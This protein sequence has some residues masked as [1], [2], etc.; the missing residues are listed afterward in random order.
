VRVDAARVGDVALDGLD[1]ATLH[2]LS[3]RAVHPALR[4]G[5]ARSI[6]PI[7]PNPNR[8]C[9]ARGERVSER[10]QRAFELSALVFIEQL[11]IL[12]ER[13]ARRGDE[14]LGLDDAL[15]ELPGAEVFFCVFVRV[16]EHALDVLVGQ[17]VAR[18]DVDGVL[19]SGRLVLRGH[20]EHPALVDAKRDEQAS[21]PC[22][23]RFDPAERESAR[24]N[25]SRGRARVR[26]AARGCR[27]PSDR[28]RT[29]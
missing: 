11:A 2:R 21:G 1:A 4:Q 20:R 16:D 29:S 10:A 9:V 25:D 13:R 28:R 26:L 7:A 23:L 24:A 14:L 19:E 27:S 18:F 3:H 17:S 6:E 5:N 15:G 22:G 12:L 8:L